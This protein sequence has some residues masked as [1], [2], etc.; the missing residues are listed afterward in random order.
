[1]FGCSSS[2][3]SSTSSCTSLRVVASRRFIRRHLHATAESSFASVPRYVTPNPPS[4]S[5]SVMEMR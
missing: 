1:M 2:R 3:S 5:R 4:P